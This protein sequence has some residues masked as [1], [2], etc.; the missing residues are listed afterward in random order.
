MEISD[1]L[2][3]IENS[4]MSAP[5][6]FESVAN[7]RA[8]DV[9]WTSDRMPES[10]IVMLLMQDLHRH[11]LAAF[12][13]VQIN[14]D[15][16]YFESNGQSLQSETLPDLKGAKIDLFVCDRSSIVGNLQLRVAVEIKGPKSKWGSLKADID[17][18]KALKVVAAGADQKFLFAYVSCPISFAAKESHDKQLVQATGLELHNFKVLPA[19]GVSLTT[20]VVSRAYIYI[21]Y[22]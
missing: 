6:Y 22:F 13:E 17:R 21:H 15:L 14:H 10:W 20:Q 5:T 3:I 19:H 12:P 18:L 7:G 1:I 2:N 11:G 9:N 4:L 16:Q 8:V